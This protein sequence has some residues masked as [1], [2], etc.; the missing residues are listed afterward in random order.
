MGGARVL[1]LITS[2]DG[3]ERETPVR[4]LRYAAAAAARWCGERAEAAGSL[5]AWWI[6]ANISAMS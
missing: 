4:M 6:E 1:S 5:A 2:Q 3:Q